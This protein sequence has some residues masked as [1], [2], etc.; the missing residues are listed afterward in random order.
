MALLQALVS[1]I[2]RSAGKILN[3]MF[4]WAVVALFGRTSP[5]EET[6]LSGVVAMA[7]AWPLLLIGVAAPKIAALLIAFVPLSSHVPSWAV[8][9]VWIVLALAVPLTVGWAVAR[10]APPGTPPEPFLI[11][12]LRGI[13]ITIAIA[14]AFGFMFVT[15]P[16]LRVASAVK[17]RRDEHVPVITHSATYDAV[18]AQ[19]ERVLERAHLGATRSAPSWWLI[20]PVSVLLKLGGKA[21]RGYIP[22]HLAYWRSDSLEL[23]LYPNDLLIRGQRTK[24]A[25]AHGL[26]AE[27]LARGPGLQTFEPEAQKLETRIQQIWSAYRSNPTAPA[28]AGRRR[29][30]LAAIARQL[31]RLPLEYDQW[32]VLYREALQLGRALNGEQQLLESVRYAAK[33]DTMDDEYRHLVVLDRPE[34]ESAPTRE[35]LSRL[36]NDTTELVKKQVQLARAEIEHDL[37]AEIAAAKGIGAAA[38]CGLLLLNMLLVAL[39]FALSTIMAGWA[40]ALL[41]AAGVLCVGGVFG[42]VGWERRVSHPLEKTRKTLKE[43]LEWAKEQAA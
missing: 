3:A 7:A 25:W 42:I 43:D 27:A 5:R 9:I 13:P 11:R 6:L 35:L 37:R 30:S 16:V 19:I 15:V 23:A 29:S 24:T 34:L 33:E 20:A 10:K 4:G 32:Q 12:V 36:I 40:A 39:V 41:V 17:G 26:M 22:E 31:G 2:S 28:A 21:F 8:R 1:L 18:V 38:V 14:C